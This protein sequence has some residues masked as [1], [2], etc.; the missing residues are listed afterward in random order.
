MSHIVWLNTPVTHRPS[1]LSIASLTALLA[2][3]LVAKFSATG[4]AVTARTAITTAIA[5]F[6]EPTMTISAASMPPRLCAFCYWARTA[7]AA[8][9]RGRSGAVTYCNRGR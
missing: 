8:A 2:I 5:I 7:V 1:V 3:I 6:I 9:S 4:A